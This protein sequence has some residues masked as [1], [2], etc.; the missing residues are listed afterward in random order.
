MPNPARGEL[1]QTAEGYV[2]RITVEGKKRQSFLLSSCRTQTEAEERKAL[3]AELAARFRKAGIIGRRDVAELMQTAAS[4]ALAILPSVRQVAAD[5]IGGDWSPSTAAAVPTFE[6]IAGDWTSHELHKLYPDHVKTKDSD[7]DEARLKKLCA[8]DVGGIKLGDIPLDQFALDHAESAMRQL[9]KEAKRP[10]TRR[11]YAQLIHRVLQLAVYP[12]RVIKVNPLPK[13]FMPKIGKPPGYSFL[14][15]EED[16]AL[17]SHRDTPL[18]YRM[19]W[20]F[21]DR[22]GM[23]SGEAISLRIGVEVDLV[24]G[25][26]SLDQN[27][28]DDAR[29]W[30]L[31]PGVAEALRRWVEQRRAKKGDLLFHDEEGLAL[32]ND[33]LAELLRSH[34]RAAGVEREELFIPGVNRG[35][36]RCHDLR[37]TFITISLANGKT[38]SWVQDRTGHTTSAMINRYRRAARSATELGLGALVPLSQAV[39][40]LSSPSDGPSEAP[41]AETLDTEDRVNYR[42]LHDKPKWRNWQTRRT[43]NPL[44]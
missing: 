5:M 10:A 33:K 34:L 8:L 40:E 22:E 39:P 17:L 3:L 21:L 35:Q 31:D 13:G 38:E 1:Y 36:L 4:C 30:A 24:R 19:L 2:A 41:K 29:A 43:Q 14:Y 7:L 27:K 28:T 18:P 6:K 11:Q 25:V 23:R 32:E 12:C 26:V 9:P 42:N 44:S 15:P 20:G 16:S 37:G